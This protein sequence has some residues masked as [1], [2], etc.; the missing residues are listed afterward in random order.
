MSTTATHTKRGIWPNP[1]ARTRRRW[2]L[3]LWNSRGRSDMRSSE[4]VSSTE[5]VADSSGLELTL[6]ARPSPS[7]S[8]TAIDSQDHHSPRRSITQS[9]SSLA[10]PSHDEIDT[11]DKDHVSISSCSHVARSRPDVVEREVTTVASS[12]NPLPAPAEASERVI[13]RHVTSNRDDPSCS[14]TSPCPGVGNDDS[15]IAN[16]IPHIVVSGDAS[17]RAAEPSLP[18]HIQ[19]DAQIPPSSPTSEATAR[20][21]AGQ[22][23]ESS[24]SIV[25][26]Q[27]GTPESMYDWSKDEHKFEEW[28]PSSIGHY[29]RK[30]FID[31]FSPAKFTVPA[32]QTDFNTCKRIS[33]QTGEEEEEV[34]PVGWTKHTHSDGKPYFY[35]DHDKVV[36]EEWL[37]ERDIA[38][39]VARYISILKDAISKRSKSFGRV[40]LWHLYVEIAQYYFVNHDAECLFW[41]SKFT[42]DGYL[43]E[44]RGEMS[45]DLIRNVT[46]SETSTVTRSIDTLKI[47]SKSIILAE[48]AYMMALLRD[49]IFNYH[50][51][52]DARTG[53]DESVYG[54]EHNNKKRTVPFRTMN[55]LLFYAPIKHYTSL[56]KVWVDRLISRGPWQHL[57][58]QITDKWQQHVGLEKLYDN[59]IRRQSFSRL[60]WPF[61]L[62]LRSTRRVRASSTSFVTQLLCYLSVAS[63]MATIIIGLILM[64]HHNALKHVDVAVV[65]EFLERHW[66]EYIGFERLS[67]MYSTPY[68]LLM[69]SMV[70]FLASF[71]LMCLESANPVSLK[72]FV[73]LAF[74]LGTALCVWCIYLFWDGSD[75][76]IQ[77]C[78]EFRPRSLSSLKE[79]LRSILSYDNICL[80]RDKLRR[81][82]FRTTDPILPTTSDG[83]V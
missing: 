52:R 73:T 1:L 70:S 83:A 57:I 33:P 74:L 38:E 21:A 51:Q 11:C 64:S 62:Y 32:M 76:W 24:E 53:R 5:D 41:L 12:P 77:R 16:T 13:S 46:M 19:C 34:L 8:L 55:L 60:I 45:P 17:P 71:F 40:K 22:I 81:A 69:W 30:T 50:G 26:P 10:A 49:Q 18:T 29:G 39:K 54:Y 63:S 28:L 82:V 56:H 72:V 36:T 20:E 78:L 2:S 35:H 65:T 7:S 31:E 6:R 9:S 79:E 23:A 75:Q 67:I 80:F 68:A 42:L 43:T 48:T 37:Y 66:Q 27:S 15:D 14:R 61:S 47:M 44:L 3:G 58:E 25:L 4:A 59:T